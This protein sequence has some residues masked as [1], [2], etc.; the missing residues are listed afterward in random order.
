MQP[1]L[2]GTRY[3]PSP[4]PPPRRRRR[5]PYPDASRRSSF[6]QI[7]AAS[8]LRKPERYETISNKKEHFTE[9]ERHSTTAIHMFSSVNIHGLG[10]LPRGMGEGVY[11]VSTKEF[12]FLLFQSLHSIVELVLPRNKSARRRRVAGRGIGEGEVVVRGPGYFSARKRLNGIEG[13]AKKGERQPV[14][15]RHEPEKD[16]AR[17]G[18][19]GDVGPAPI[20]EER[21]DKDRFVFHGRLSWPISLYRRIDSDKI[22]L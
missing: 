1:F 20:G 3:P 12:F 10:D 6:L 4:P 11:F 22:D 8:I 14:V 16:S 9:T 15:I 13:Y 7:T 19:R 5:A 2:S 21:G 17:D 18:G